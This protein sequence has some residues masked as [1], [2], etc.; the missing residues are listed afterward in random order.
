MCSVSK[1][2]ELL[3]AVQQSGSADAV[4]QVSAVKLKH[5]R[6]AFFLVDVREPDEIAADPIH[7]PL[8]L[9]DDD[10]NNGGNAA[11]AAAAAAPTTTAATATTATT[12]PVIT[13]DAQVTAGK[14]LR[15]GGTDEGRAALAEWSGGDGDGK[16][17]KRIVLLCHSGYRASIVAREL[18]QRA[19]AGIPNTVAALTRGLIGLRNPA[20]TVPDALV[21][22]ATKSSGE[23]MTLALNACA[24]AATSTENHNKTV[25]L[26][27]MG[28]GVCTFLR[29]GNNKELADEQS[30]R[31]EETFVGPPFQPCHAL[32]KKFVGSGNGAVLAC[33]SCCRSRGIEF[34]SDLL[35][36][37]QPLQ[38]PDLLR[39]LS[40][41]KQ[42]LQF[43]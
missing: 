37:V 36:C 15:L 5:S 31:M 4:P 28:D 7:R 29:K 41:S 11:A 10:N 20:A 24:V 23:K 26:V 2:N 38:M 6:D 16:T 33:T 8:P 1:V 21:V 19:G 42:T 43:M 27:L 9:P 14:L 25:V 35:D 30:L 32:L 39:M 22:L 12:S 17:K 34:G 40:E 18:N 3:G 13:A